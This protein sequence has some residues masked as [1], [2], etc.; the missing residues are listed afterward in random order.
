MAEAMTRV[1][2]LSTSGNLEF[3]TRLTPAKGLPSLHSQVDSRLKVKGSR[4]GSSGVH[5]G[6]WEDGLSSSLWE[7]ILFK[8]PVTKSFFIS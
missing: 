2:I 1:P 6:P 5:E 7:N 3:R 4:P 8:C